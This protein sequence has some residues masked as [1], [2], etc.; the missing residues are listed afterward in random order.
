MKNIP[1]IIHQIWSDKIKP[2]PEFFSELSD[3][4]KDMYADW[5]YILWNDKKIDTYVK[6]EYS[7]IYSFFQSLPMDIQRWDMVRYLFLYQMGGMYVDFDYESIEPLDEL[8]GDACC[9]FS[10]EP[11]EHAKLFDQELSVNN[12]LILCT[13]RQ[14]FIKTIIDHILTLYPVT[15]PY[16]DSFTEVLQTTGPGMV[17]RLY[18][19]YQEK[20]HIRILLPEFVSP[21][22]KIEVNRYLFTPHS[23][24]EIL[25]QKLEKAYAVHYFSGSWY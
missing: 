19:Q 20:E 24:L 17:T 1:K 22:T 15:D 10:S 14:S 3:T 7:E 4:W 2:L 11:R 16:E 5:E 12:G 13:P 18:E 6:N 25:E 23:D 8:V 9:C 21:L